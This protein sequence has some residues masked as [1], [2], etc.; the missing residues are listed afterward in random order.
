[1]KLKLFTPLLL[2]STAIT[3]SGCESPEEKINRLKTEITQKGTSTENRLS[4]IA[5]LVEIDR[6]H[7]I[8]PILIQILEGKD[9]KEIHQRAILSLGEIKPVHQKS[10]PTL[11]SKLNDR[12]LR[13]DII[14]TLGKIGS[15]SYTALINALGHDETRDNSLYA[16]NQIGE[17]ALPN[18]LEAIQQAPSADILHQEST[19]ST[20]VRRKIIET[21][22]KIGEPAT[23]AV[24]TLIQEFNN[25][26]FDFDIRAASQEFDLI[27]R[28]IEKI[29]ESAVNMLTEATENSN[30]KT[31]TGAAISLYRIDRSKQ[32]I[33]SPILIGALENEHVGEVVTGVLSDIG[34]STVPA[35]ENIIKH[36]NPIAS[37]HAIIALG[38][39]GKAAIPILIRLISSEIPETQLSA[40]EALGRTGED[41]KLAIPQLIKLL[42]NEDLSESTAIAL[43]EIGKVA[44]PHLINSLK[45]RDRNARR[46]AA[47]A[48]SE[49]GKEA[50]TA[51]N[52]LTKLLK[53]P[54]VGVDAALALYRIDNS[55]FNSIAPTLKS[56]LQHNDYNI[57]LRANQIIE[58]IGEATVPMLLQ[59]LKDKNPEVRESSAIL[60]GKVTTEILV[61]THDVTVTSK[62]NIELAVP[63]LINVIEDEN[64]VWAIRIAASD[65]L[66]MASESGHSEASNALMTFNQIKR[67]KNSAEQ[68]EK[69]N[70][71]KFLRLSDELVGIGLL[72]VPFLIKKFESEVPLARGR[73]SSVL[74]KI[75]PPAIPALTKALRNSNKLIATWS[76]ITLQKIKKS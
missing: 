65:G 20:I 32:N 4:A 6:P 43:S 36:N 53:D 18:L 30:V 52:T 17:P 27:C 2:L 63:A 64:E 3:I 8:S 66:K 42:A 45:S 37:R 57:N 21:I 16:L 23:S 39:I 46:M 76:E 71:L 40:I 11:I 41:A 7:I 22:G 50:K 67:A 58:Q 5:T 62:S 75:G 1:M 68:I 25:I 48:L 60:L 19:N 15:K 24:P 61:T 10:I 74:T 14:K 33:V 35:L 26:N 28:T 12:T 31:R 51:T 73:S 44:V 56:G 29:G 54:Y 34:E 59:T 38:K 55:K 72:A 13:D 47:I 49:I 69:A 9:K 70:E